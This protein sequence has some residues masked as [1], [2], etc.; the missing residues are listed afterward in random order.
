MNNC[1]TRASKIR[2]Q[3]QY[4]NAHKEVRRSVR[5][6]KRVYIGSLAK[7]AEEA[8]AKRNIKDLY[9]ELHKKAG[10]KASACTELGEGQI[11]EAFDYSRRT[12]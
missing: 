4:G 2:V 12:T 1:R 9:I 7:A 3:K 5:T 8:A 6:D 11:R 10:R